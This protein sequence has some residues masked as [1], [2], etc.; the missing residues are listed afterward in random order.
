[1]HL[2]LNQLEIIFKNN[3]D[4]AALI[5]KNEK[6]YHLK[7]GESDIYYRHDGVEPKELSYI[8]KN[9][10]VGV[11]KGK[12]GD[13][14]NIHQ[15]MLHHMNNNG[16]IESSNSNTNGSKRLWMNFIKNNKNL[17]H[18][19]FNSTTNV[20]T[21]LNAY[22]IDAESSKIWSDNPKS[23]NIRIITKK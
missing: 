18:S 7:H 14:K 10:Q 20:N 5:N 12:D 3:H 9:I 16:T 19:A 4:K 6:H 22:N 11:E 1:M 21:K 13:S 8:S 15:F 2:G 23:A 17:N